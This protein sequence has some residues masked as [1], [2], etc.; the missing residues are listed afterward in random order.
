M[1]T[2]LL[3]G[4]LKK[5]VNKTRNGHGRS[6]RSN[7]RTS[8]LRSLVPNLSTNVARGYKNVFIRLMEGIS[9]RLKRC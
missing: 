1:L 5:K 3:K 9:W 6:V 7:G 8:K 2:A 4:E